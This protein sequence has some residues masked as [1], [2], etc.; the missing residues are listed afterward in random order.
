SNLT[1]NTDFAETEVDQRLVNLTRFP[2]FFP[3]KR[4]FFLD[5][6]TF[7]DFYRGGDGSQPVRPYFSR[8]IGLDDEG[9]QQPIA[10]GG[11][12]TGQLGR[13][14]V[15]VLYVHTDDTG[16]AASEDFS[17]VR[18]KQRFW[19]QSY[20]AGIYT[21]RR[22]PDAGTQNTVGMDFR[23]ATARFRGSQNL[24]FDTFAVRTDDVGGLG[25]NWSYG[26]RIGFPN[27]PWDANLS[28]EVV[29][30]NV[31]PVVGFVPRTG[32]KNLNPR[33][34]Y[35]PRPRN[36]SW[37]RRLDFSAG[38]ELL[39]DMQNRWLTREIDWQVLR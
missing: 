33:A 20:I 7:F 15:G 17:V 26:T 9:Q 32:F 25:Q 4:T 19:A 27:D 28:Y 31:D 37:I 3:E 30:E 35:R 5:G 14:D 29:E 24:E 13:Q 38:A 6:A 12:I 34:S 11:K 39:V 1:V 36:H 10:I 16:T 23:L 21:G 22:T 2:L 18:L 8:R